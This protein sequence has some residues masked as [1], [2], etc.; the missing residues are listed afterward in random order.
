MKKLFLILFIILGISSTVNAAAPYQ[1]PPDYGC[2]PGVP[3]SVCNPNYQNNNTGNSIKK[4]PVAN[5]K[6]I[7]SRDNGK[8]PL[9]FFTMDG[10]TENEAVNAMAEYCIKSGPNGCEATVYKKYAAVAIS[11]E[12]V[13]YLARSE[14]SKEDAGEKVLKSCKKKYKKSC[15]LVGTYN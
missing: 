10:V 14:K 13:H 11:E 3:V 5:W 8:A 7:I 15:S 12:G 6:I 4:E 1:G 9:E 2:G